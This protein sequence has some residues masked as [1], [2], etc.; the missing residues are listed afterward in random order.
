MAVNPFA[1][2]ASQPQASVMNQFPESGVT[3]M[4][5]F[6]T[7]QNPTLRS[8]ARTAPGGVMTTNTAP[9]AQTPQAQPKPALMGSGGPRDALRAYMGGQSDPAALAARRRD[10]MM[11]SPSSDPR[12]SLATFLTGGGAAVRGG[13]NGNGVNVRPPSVMR[14][15]G[16]YR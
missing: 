11:R 12:A 4:P 7:N 5:S 2:P 13:V 9:P 15:V 10:P 1:S 3:V 6:S 14:P 16:A 8:G